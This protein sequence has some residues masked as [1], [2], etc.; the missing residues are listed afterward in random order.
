MES[1][2]SSQSILHLGKETILSCSP[3]GFALT[4]HTLVECIQ[5]EA[6]SLEPNAWFLDEG[7]LIGPLSDL[8]S[9]LNIVENNGPPQGLHLNRGKSLLYT[10]RDS[11]LLKDI[12][13]TRHGFNLLR[14]PVGL[15][16]YCEEVLQA[17]EAR[18]RRVCMFYKI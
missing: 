3:L 12:P 16:S 5:A 14:F 6:T 11:P 8:S 4:L 2:Y 1:C 13:V 9:A 10:P 17:R 18:S 15:A 7:T